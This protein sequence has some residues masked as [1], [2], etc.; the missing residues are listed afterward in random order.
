[1]NNTIEFVLRMRDMMSSNINKVSATSQSVFNKMSQSANQMTGRNNILGMSFDELQKKIKQVES[2]ISKST[3][4]S[5]IAEARRE[6]ALLQRQSSNHAGN[7]NN[8][9]SGIGIG[10]VAVG[11]VL[12]GL[13]STGL[14]AVKDGIGMMVEGTMNKESAINGMST[15]LGKKDAKDAYKNIQQDA[16]ATPFDTESLLTVNRSL[17]SAGLNAKTA[18]TDTMNLANAVVAVGGTND[19][20]TRMAANMQQI[21]T[22]GKATSMDIRQFGIAGINIYEMLARS[23][24]K[25]IN[26]VKEMDV[27][28]EQLQKALQM[29]A[30]AGGIYYGALANAQNS[31]QGKWS[32]FKESFVNGLAAA[33]DAFRPL[34]NWVLDFGSAIGNGIK[35]I[36]RFAQ[37][38]NS[39]STSAG[40]FLAVAG[41]VITLF[42]LYATGLGIIAA[43]TA[44]VTAAQ[45]AWNIAATANPFVWVIVAIASLVILYKK[46]AG[47]RA[48]VDGAWSSLQQVGSNIMDMFTKIPD[49]IIKSFTQIPKAIAAA[50]SNVGELFSAIFNGDFSKIPGILKNLG[51]N[52]LKTNPITGFGTQVVDEVTKNTGAAFKQGFRQSM[53]DTNKDVI[54]DFAK[55][56]IDEINSSHFKNAAEYQKKVGDFANILDRNVKSGLITKNN[57]ASILS[58]L[59]DEKTALATGSDL[60]KDNATSSEKAGDTVSGAGPKVINIHVGKFFDNLQ[61]TTLNMQETAQELENITMECLSRVLYNGAKTI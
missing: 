44:I 43:K 4:P 1:M 29:S 18:R 49:M 30:G 57:K 46:V 48:F 58:K 31:L 14:S 38:L 41:G 19:T 32:N 52:I 45:W 33:G 37:W 60:S 15:F 13:V 59:K 20:L 23:T 28:Y 35:Y 51:G 56:N 54:R 50:F 5:Q 34:I 36:A 22:V 10:G 16:Q 12:G 39:S 7:V 9:S 53:L 3:V 11:S 21:K 47:F 2:T 17:I 61:F 40:V 42:A 26:Q 27:T 8:G 55:K 24:G 6:L 25:N